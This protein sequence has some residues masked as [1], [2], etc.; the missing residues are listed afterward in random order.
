MHPDGVYTLR[1]C[2]TRHYVLALAARATRADFGKIAV[3]ISEV[4]AR[5]GG[6]NPGSGG[7]STEKREYGKAKH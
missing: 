2:I 7:L 3:A 1:L 6:L 5:V 4:L